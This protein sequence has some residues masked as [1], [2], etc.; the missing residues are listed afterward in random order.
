[1]NPFTYHGA[2]AAIVRFVKFGTKLGTTFCKAYGNIVHGYYTD[3]GRTTQD[4]IHV[5]KAI[6]ERLAGS[7]SSSHIILR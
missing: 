5:I 6:E 4:L 1:M 3:F 7:T 2:A